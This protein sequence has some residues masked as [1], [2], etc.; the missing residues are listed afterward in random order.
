MLVKYCNAKCQRNHWPKH[1]K[2][3][4]ERAAELRD[5]ALFKHPPAKEDCPI[6]FLPMPNELI[7]FISLPPATITSV[8]IYD[9]AIANEELRNMGTEEYFPCCGKSICVGCIHSFNTSENNDNCPF[10]NSKRFGKTDKEKVEELMKRV[11]ANDAGAIYIL[12][13]Y[14]AHGQLGLQQ[15]MAKGVDLWT[16]A[17]KLGS[18]HSHFHLGCTYGEGGNLKKA[19]FHYEAAAMAG[20]ELARNNLGTM[21]AQSGN[22]ERAVKHWMISASAGHHGAMNNLLITFKQGLVS[23]NAMDSTLTAYNN[24]CAEM[25]SEARDAFIQLSI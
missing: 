2:E 21:E 11:E 12:G 22:M 4:K 14:Y 18:S 16:Q 3:C 9:Y 7:C 13:S 23:R 1:K 15:E 10:C 24:S 5:E 8:P 25:R 20:H 6:C 17:S 19:K